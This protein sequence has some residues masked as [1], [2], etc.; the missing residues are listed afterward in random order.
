VTEP[1]RFRALVLSVVKHAY[2]PQAVASHPRFDLVAVV[3]D[4]DQ[5]DWVHQRNQ[6]FADEHELPYSKDFQQAVRQHSPDVAIVSSQ[7][8]RHCELSIRAA[9]AG[10]HVIVDKPLSTRLSEC[11]RLVEAIERTGVRCLMWNRNLMPALLQAKATLDSGAIGDLRAIHCDFYFSKDAGPPK[12]SRRPGQPPINW[13]ERQIEAHADGSDGGVGV[14]PMGELQNEGI[15][16]LA[17]LRMLTRGR[18]VQRVFARTA[19]HFHQAHVDND[20][21]DLAT[22]TL[23]LEGGLLGSLCIGRIGA[24]SHPELG[25]IK[26]HLLGTKGAL[27]VSEPRPEVSIHYRGQPAKEFRNLR[28]ADENNFLLVENFAAAIDTGS[29]TILDAQAGRDICAVVE[30]CVRSGKSGKLEAPGGS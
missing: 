26:L 15:Y 30:A 27:V 11:D 18:R 4:A 16:P 29:E 22:V 5:P 19:A 2:L 21:D 17:Y 6:Q 1:Q 8:E 12:G 24:A 23:E 25:E 3:D 9:E 20:V 13:L 7:A 10:L 28:V 14:E